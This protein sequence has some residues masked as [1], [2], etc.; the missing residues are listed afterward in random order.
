MRPK[1][2]ARQSSRLD[3]VVQEIVTL[4]GSKGDTDDFGTE[5]VVRSTIQS[6][7]ILTSR[8]KPIWGFKRSNVAALSALLKNIGDIRKTL[9]GMP[10]ELLALL[11]V[12]NLSEQVPSLLEQQNARERLEKIIAP[13]NY[14]QARGALLLD[15][16]PGQHGS[17]DFSQRLVADEAWRLMKYHNVKPTSGAAS[18]EYGKIASLLFEAVT[19][20]DKDYKD[21]Q[22]ACKSA[23]ERAKKGELNEWRGQVIFKGRMP[24]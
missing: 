1:K 18:S 16:Q 15:R 7:K 12:E 4:L 5:V 8:D 17:A 11:A 20:Q 2:A 10:G 21:L 9:S 19:G 3:E 14:L 23:L 22:R 13:L 6:L 24:T